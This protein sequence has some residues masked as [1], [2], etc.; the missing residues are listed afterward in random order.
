MYQ[1]KMGVYKNFFQTFHLPVKSN[2][3]PWRVYLTTPIKVY[4]K[5]QK[6]LHVVITQN[7]ILRPIELSNVILKILW[8]T[9]NVFFKRVSVIIYRLMT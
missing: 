6:S 8:Q 4:E 1:H 7:S 9:D 2:A 5:R 3:C